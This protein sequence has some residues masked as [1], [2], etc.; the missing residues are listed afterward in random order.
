M[1]NFIKLSAL[2]VIM[3]DSKITATK[4]QRAKIN[5]LK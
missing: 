3:V 1:D 5:S 2:N 4:T